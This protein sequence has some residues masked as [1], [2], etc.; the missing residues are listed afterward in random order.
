MFQRFRLLVVLVLACGVLK[1]PG[2]GADPKPLYDRSAKALYNLDF[3]TAEQGFETLTRDYPDSPD[4]WNALASAIFLRITFEQ[5]KLNLESWATGL[6]FGTRESTDEVNPAEEKR[7][8]TI[9]STTIAKADALLKKDPKDVHAL[10]QKGNAEVTLASFEGTIKGSVVGAISNARVAKSTHLQVLMMDPGFADARA[11]IGTYDYFVAVLPAVLRVGASLFGLGTEGKEVG[12]QH[13]EAAAAKGQYS[14]TDAKV[15]LA[16]IYS[17][18][19][20]YAEALKLMIDLHSEYPHNFVF[21][22]AEAATYGKLKR[23][24]EARRIYFG[25]LE[26]IQSKSDGYDRVRAEKVY[27]LLGIDDFQTGLFDM[28]L[29]NLSRVTAGKNATL[30]EKAGAHLWIG[31][32]FDSRKDRTHAVEEYRAAVSLNCSADL[33]SEARTYIRRPFGSK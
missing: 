3:P 15:L 7:F 27:Y 16:V 30:D 12:I 8:R 21:Q 22:F 14:S 18:E 10:Y 33:K 6:T 13:L 11:S 1:L 26:N 5:Q 29:E 20:R 24:D 28:A 31:K 32:I 2:A 25:I 9:V 17:R 4:Y 23:Y 19:T